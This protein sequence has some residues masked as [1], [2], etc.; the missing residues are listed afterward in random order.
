VMK[1]FGSCPKCNEDLPPR[2]KEGVECTTCGSF[3]RS[4]K[5]NAMFLQA[6]TVLGV[7]LLYHTFP[8][9]LFIFIP[10]MGYAVIRFGKYV[11][12]GNESNGDGQSDS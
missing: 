10:I 7:M 9:L 5:R 11:V 6:I 2:I 4:D 12:V 1:I 8:A 3:V